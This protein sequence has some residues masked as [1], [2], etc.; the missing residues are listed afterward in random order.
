[1][2]TTTGTA[3][4]TRS[5]EADVAR[6][7]HMMVHSVYSDKD[8][9]LRELI[10]N[11]A[12][13]CEKLRYELL[14]DPALA[15]DDGQPRITVTLDPEAR[16]L[17][18]EDNGIGMSEVEL[19][20]ALGTIAR[21]GTR[22]FMERVAAVREGA[23]EGEGAQLIGQFGVG[24]YSAFMVADRVDVFSRRAG[25]DV[26]AHWASDGL[27]SYTI[28]LV[29]IA[30]APAR[31]TRIVLHLKEDAASY[32]E[33]FTTQR[34]V[35][36]QSGHVPVPIFLK[37]KPDAEEKQ[38]ADG[39][40][41]WTRPRSD[42]TAEEYAD[43]YRSTAGQF[44]EPALTLHYRAEGL[45]EY[46][47]LAFLP[48][49]RPFDLFDPDRAGRM[50]LYVRRVFIT[51]EAQI[52]PRYLRFVRGLV[53]SNDLPLNVSREMI[54]ESPVLAAV[55]KGVANRILSELDKLAQK[56]GEAYLKFWD[57]F[58]A[59][60]KE[61]LYEDFARREALLGLARFKST[62]SG[63]GW[64]S[65]K[66]YVEAIKDNQTAIYY[67]T[68]ADLDRL[69]SSP[70]L[71]GFRARGIEVLLLT[72][73]VD[74]FWVTAGVDYQGKPF[75]S[76]T[77]GLADLS[78]IPLA[79]GEAPA[80]EAS[81]E[82]DG[83]IAYA[84]DV[85]GEAVSDVRA[86]ERLT[87]SA[88]CLVAPDNA[89]DR[90]LEKLLAGAGRIDNAAR[91]VLEI[92]PR[93]DLI[94]KLGTLPDGSDLRADAAWLLLDEARIADGELPADPRAFS[95]RLARMIGGAIE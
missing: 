6:L 80:A 5:F 22:A 4:E 1:M 54:Q 60:L 27:G 58:G 17:I 39:A 10:S 59:V 13:A 18:V 89:M 91:P 93:H 64:R 87:E 34:I 32:T 14:S 16:Q 21:S 75:K 84:R 48:S 86:S 25:A 52:L 9:F 28:Q 94:V 44:D 53:D 85:L 63:E 66:D 72:D 45:H 31:G 82:V 69:A 47:V 15:G 24:F 68:G 8:V 57:N 79:E 92:N 42:I 83:F 70:Q 36:A 62:A 33:P 35:T 74:S 12:D 46:S 30:D 40:A 38:I 49:M 95:A 81:A 37:E 90:Q 55:Q 29:D 41:L 61:G 26:A 11:A 3:P 76:V 19:A 7:L 56:D 73:Q 43:F 51:D 20:E 78:L 50:K 77:Q 23:K 2:T 65:L 88:V 67:A 71:E